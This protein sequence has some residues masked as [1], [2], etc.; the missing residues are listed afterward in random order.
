M[1]KTG[2]IIYIVIY[3]EEEIKEIKKIIL[4]MNSLDNEIF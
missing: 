1:K 2:N 4:M 3:M